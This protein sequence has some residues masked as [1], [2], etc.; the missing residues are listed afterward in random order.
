MV[1]LCAIAA[2]RAVIILL[3]DNKAVQRW[4]TARLAGA[5]DNPPRF[6][7]GLWREVEAVIVT[8]P[9]GSTCFWVP[10]HGR[11]LDWEA[12][13]QMRMPTSKARAVNETRQLAPREG[14][15]K[16][17]KRCRI[18][19]PRKAPRAAE[20]QWRKRWLEPGGQKHATQAEPLAPALP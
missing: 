18:M 2:T 8:M 11:K 3:I 19:L 14:T 6:C 12:S 16:G 1:A 13:C 10:A 20:A 9:P 17:G 15:E 7:F 4:V 5:A